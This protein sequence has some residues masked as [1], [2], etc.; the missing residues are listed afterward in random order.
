[1]ALEYRSSD[2]CDRMAD[3]TQFSHRNPRSCDFKINNMNEL[4]YSNKKQLHST[5]SIIVYNLLK[6]G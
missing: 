1:M 5:V 3:G 4:M 6:R 2:K